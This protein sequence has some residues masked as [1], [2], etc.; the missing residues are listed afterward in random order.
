MT[1]LL[2][3]LS[4]TFSLAPAAEPRG[5]PRFETQEIAK[6]LKIGYAVHICDI[7]GDRKP[8]IVVVDK[9]RVVWY[10]NPTWKMHTIITGK[11]KPDNV[12]IA[13]V[14][15]DG[16][17]KLD[18]VLGA[19]WKPF[20]TSVPG[21]MQWLGRGK[22]LDE[23][24]TV[25][26]IPCD[27]PTVH[28]VL[29]ANLENKGKPQILMAPLMGRGSSAKANWADGRP[30][31]IIAY[32]IPKDPTKPENWKPKVVIDQL[33]VVHNFTATQ[34]HAGQIITTASY[35][36]VHEFVPQA[37]GGFLSTKIGDGNQA[38][39][40]SNRGSSEISVGSLLHLRT[41]ATV[42]PWHG[43]QI[44]AYHAALSDDK[45]TYKRVVLDDHLR[46]GHAVKF[47]DLLG[48]KNEMIVA[49]VRDNPNAKQ[50]DTFTEKCGVRIY[51]RPNPNSDK[52]D[53]TLLDEGGVAVEDLAVA[54]L[55]GDGKPDIIAVGRATGNCRIYWNRGKE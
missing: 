45:L 22:T 39:P 27:E 54:D 19:G 7:N 16:D 50:G 31:R 3:S 12:C 24:W 34:T 4:L 49:G 20:D 40:K 10:E 47:A 11:T 17:G 18:L 2:V 37:G 23:E 28:R 44:V 9:E 6:D 36:G 13:S 32:D 52:W 14:D 26:P 21:T 29:V 55:N 25:H 43:H 15:I 1:P 51:R 38:N 42:E 35:E 30:S 41:I 5:F 33:R 8:D 53:R 48:D 46:W